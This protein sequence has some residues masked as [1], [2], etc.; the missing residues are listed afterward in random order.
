MAHIDEI[1][2]RIAHEGI[3]MSDYRPGQATAEWRAMCADALDAAAKATERAPERRDEIERLYNRYAERAASYIN[4]RNRIDAMCPSVLITGAGNFPTKKK[5]RQVTRMDAFYKKDW[6]FDKML[7][8]LSTIGT[9]NEAIRSDDADA[10]GKLRAKLKRREADQEAMKAANAWYRRHKT[11]DGFEPADVR[12]AARKNLDFERDTLYFPS[13]EARDSHMLKT[14]PFASYQLGNNSAEIRRIK[15]RIESLLRE[16]EAASNGNGERE[17]TIND[18]P[19]RVVENA[20]DMRLQIFFDGKPDEDT[21]Q[22]VKS[23][24]FRWA[25]SVGAWQRQLTDNARH[26]L[27]RIATY[28]A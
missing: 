28:A 21:R 11:M 15:K 16:K 17:A 25:P 5:A 23:A 4:E 19:C 1:T 6:G 22:Q 13:D 14:K 12:E 7:R 8:K 18:E 10:V 20:D 9:A 26:A 27:D 3:H 24:G 2:A